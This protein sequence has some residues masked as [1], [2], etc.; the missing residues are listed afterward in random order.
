MSVHP[1]PTRRD[2]LGCPGKEAPAFQQKRPHVTKPRH[3]GPAG[4]AR[5]SAISVPLP[6]P[7]LEVR[8]HSSF[9]GLRSSG[10]GQE[11][12]LAAPAQGFST[13]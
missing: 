7:G 11:R 12:N 6:V 10:A 1:I 13:L 2:A 8:L 9:N 4:K 5:R 3:P